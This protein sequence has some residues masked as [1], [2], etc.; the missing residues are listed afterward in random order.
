ML[1]HNSPQRNSPQVSEVSLT[2]LFLEIIE[3]SNSFK[4]VS[5]ICN[6]LSSFPPNTDTASPPF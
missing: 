5:I 2:I 3:Q 1:Y 4:E 6:D